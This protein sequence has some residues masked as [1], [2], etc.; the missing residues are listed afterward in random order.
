M[1]RM[2]DVVSK[3]W[4]PITGCLHFCRYC[5]ARKLVERRLR[6]TKKY[7]NGFSPQMHENEFRK[8]FNGDFVFVCDMG[9]L[10][11]DWVP[12]EWILKVIEHIKKFPDTD[13]L[14]LTKNPKRYHEYIDRFPE[15]AVLGATIETN[16][17]DL[18]VEHKISRAPLPSERFKAMKELRWKNKFV[19][20]E[21]ILDF[22]LEAFTEWIREIKPVMVYIGYD[23]YG[24][25]LPEPPLEKTKALIQS[26]QGFT[27]VRVKTL[28]NE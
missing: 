2:F 21:P 23:N 20:I 28:R 6:H 3:T 18:Y 1:S 7:R 13:F 4:N 17:D 14:F 27:E 24:N 10:F 9:D 22:D 19:S 26:L 15:N 5:W 16:R 8:R 12:R 25:K 11:G